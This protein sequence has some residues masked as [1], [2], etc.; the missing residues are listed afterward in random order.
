MSKDKSSL[1]GNCWV[2]LAPQQMPAP[3]AEYRFAPPRKWR[4]D[5][6]FP[7]EMIAVEVEGNAW[8]VPG[9]GRHMQD[10]DLD[11]Y[12]HA[13]ALGW[14]VLRFS[15]G[16][17]DRDPR[18]CVDLVVKALQKPDICLYHTQATDGVHVILIDRCLHP[19]REKWNDAAALIGLDVDAPVTMP[20][21]L[22]EN[23]GKTPENP[24]YWAGTKDED[25]RVGR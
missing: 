1:F 10:S 14:R 3:V 19:D 11:K 24:E 8:R 13:A 12:N 6:A 18:G 7:M 20:D 5:W 23:I 22:V 21:V 25:E 4:F 2:M 16:M 9:G 15:P 17:L